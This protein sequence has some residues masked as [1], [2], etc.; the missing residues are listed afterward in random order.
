MWRGSLRQ[1]PV[2]ALLDSEDPALVLFARRDLLGGERVPVET[3]WEFAPVRQILRKQLDDG[4]WAGARGKTP[5]YPE[6]HADLVATFKQFRLLVERYELTSSVPEVAG[7]AEYLFGF[8][9]PEGDIRGFIANQYATYYT[10]YVLSLLIRSSYGED[11][12]VDKGMR[13]LLSMRQDDGGWTVPVLT[14]H[15]DGETM[16]RLTSQYDEAVQTD[17]AQPFS[18]NWTDMVLR[19]FAVHPRYRSSPEAERA[20]ELLK[21]R[22]FQPDVYSSYRAARY[23]T[24]FIHWWPNLLTSLESL[25]L[26]GFAAD[27][28]DIR[29]GLD[30]LIAHQGEDG[31]WRLSGDDT[32]PTPSP[33]VHRERTWLTLRICRVLKRLLGDG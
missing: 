28:P 16:R 6:N 31:L 22:F 19:A 15:F 24:R 32:D 27:D 4:S 12:R 7:T 17:R 25:S 10:G 5:V 18:H 26:L 2:S 23:W 13:W 29:G 30:W 14:H 3:I 1:D 9:T 8:Q 20:G 33:R 11:T 21:S